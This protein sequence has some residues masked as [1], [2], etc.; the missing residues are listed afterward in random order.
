MGGLKTDT[1]A[2]LTGSKVRLRAAESYCVRAQTPEAKGGLGGGAFLIDGGNSFDVYLFSELARDHHL[3]Y[4]SALDRQ[5]LSRAFTVYELL[6]LIEGSE[7]VLAVR[8]PKLLVISD[9]FSLFTEDIEKAEARRLFRGIANCVSGISKREKVPI[10][11]TSADR[12]GLLLPI[13]EERCSVSA[14]ITEGDLWTRSRLFKHPSKAPSDTFSE[15][16]TKR[17]NQDVL[18]TEV[19]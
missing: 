11:L 17:Y 8:K 2:L 10:L 1:I 15:V 7:A 19:R 5:L 13:L 18:Q 6:S 4:D 14:D 3:A 16:R 12:P 9:V